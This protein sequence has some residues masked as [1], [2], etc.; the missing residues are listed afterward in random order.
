MTL[1]WVSAD[2][3]TGGIIAD[4]PGVLAPDA[5]RRSV[6]NY[7]TATLTLDLGGAPPEDWERATMPCAAVLACY[8]DAEDTPGVTPGPIQWAGFV[9]QRVRDPASAQVSLSLATLEAY[10]DRRY[11]G[12]V[13]WPIATHRDDLI[14]S[15]LTQ[16]VKTTGADAGID[17]LRLNYKA[18]G[19]PALGKSTQPPIVWQNTDNATVLSRLTDVLGRWGGEFAVEWSWSSD[20]TALIPTVYFGDRVGTSATAGLGPA[21]AFE[22]P[23][24]IASA[25]STEDYSQDSGA[26][27]IVA[28]SSGQGSVTPYAPPVR[29]TKSGFERPTFEYRYSPVSSE[30]D[31]TVLQTYAKKQLAQMAPG[32]QSIAVTLSRDPGSTVARRLGVDWRLGDDIGLIIQPCDAFPAGYVSAGRVI[33]YEVTDTIITPTFADPTVYA[34]EA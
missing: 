25:Q 8:D 14:A 21:V 2:L 3:R 22:F 1:Q 7:D 34:V 12:D 17:N 5:L 27:K 23:G 20:N 31:T 32:K 29:A 13:T 6:S 28:Y 15:M 24:S 19:G 4:L 16:N 10:F 30:T 26:N 9:T 33:A 18:G 11:V